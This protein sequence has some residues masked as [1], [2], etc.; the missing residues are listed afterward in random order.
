VETERCPGCGAK[1]RPESSWCSLCYQDLR[2]EPVLVTSP[3]SATQGDPADP[4]APLVEASLEPEPAEWNSASRDDTGDLDDIVDA[5]IVG[6]DGRII[7][8]RSGSHDADP[9]AVTIPDLVADRQSDDEAS[10]LASLTWSCKC[11]EIVS[12]EHNVCSVCGGSFLGD[13][14]DG[15]GGRHR[16]GNSPLNWLPESRQVRLAM[17]VFAAMA[18]SVIMTLII[19][20]FG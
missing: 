9:S 17:A 10:R 12:F 19:S 14:R 2:P 15:T 11:G 4:S 8:P 7:V 3:A 5:E 18:F 16:P 1:V 20:L 13:L 6:D